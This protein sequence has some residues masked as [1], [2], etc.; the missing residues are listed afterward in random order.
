[1]KKYPKSKFPKENSRSHTWIKFCNYHNFKDWSEMADKI[2][3]IIW[4]NGCIDYET[5]S[6]WFDIYY[7]PLYKVMVEND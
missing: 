7:S 5:Y 4:R 2:V 3:E 1:M 6:H